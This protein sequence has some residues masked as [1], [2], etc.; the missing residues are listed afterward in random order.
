MGADGRIVVLGIG[1]VLLHD[2]GFGP[3]VVR[4]LDARYEFPEGVEV[5]DGGTPGL[6]FHP[7]FEGTRVL[8]VIDTVEIDAPAGTV[9]V[10]DRE[11]VLNMPVLPRTTPHEPG[12]GEALQAGLFAG[13]TPEDVVLVGVR[14]TDVSTGPGLTETVRAAAEP[15]IEAVLAELRRVGAEPRPKVAPDTPD[16]W[17]EAPGAGGARE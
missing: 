2:D 7:F 8:I 3:Y 1:N 13:E 15:A 11:K 9:R 12:L 17:W 10:Y 14:A 4:Q 6:D 16:I 5:I